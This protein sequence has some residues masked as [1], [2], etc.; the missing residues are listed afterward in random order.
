[1]QKNRSWKYPYTPLTKIYKLLALYLLIGHQLY[2]QSSVAVYSP[3]YLYDDGFEMIEKSNFNAARVSFENYLK[4]TVINGN[5]KRAFAEYYVAYSA[6]N[7]YNLDAEQLFVNFLEKYP[8]HP[9]AQKA[10]FDLGNFFFQDKNYKDAIRYLSKV[11]YTQLSNEQQREARFNLA[12]SYFNQRQFSNALSQFNML[13]RSASEYKSASAYYAAY[14]EF[15][16]KDYDDALTDLRIAESGDAYKSLVPVVICNIYYQQAK[17][18]ELIDYGEDILSN[19]TKLTNVKDIYLLTGEGYFYKENYAKANIFYQEFKKRNK[20]KPTTDVALRMAITDFNLNN[21]KEAIA[22]L[23]LIAGS[24]TKSGVA[25]SYYLGGLYTRENNMEFAA[26]AYKI[27]ANQELDAEISQKAL[28]QYGKISTDL[29]RSVEAINNLKKYLENYPSGDNVKEVND[30]LSLAY[31]NS[32]NLDLAIEHMETLS[33]MSDR[34][35]AAYQKA[36]FLKGNQLFNQHKYKPAIDHYDKSLKYPVDLNLRLE[37]HYW[38]SEAFA[39]GRLYEEAKPGYEIVI[40]GNDSDLKTK[41]SY[42]LGFCLFN[43]KEYAKA[44]PLYREFTN[45]YKGK[46]T[47]RIYQDATLRL[48][49]CYYVAKEYTRAQRMY[50]NAIQNGIREMDYAYLQLGTIENINNDFLSGKDHLRKLVNDFPHSSYVDDAL[51]ELASIDYERGNYQTCISVF[52][53]LIDEK[54]NSPYVPYSLQRRAISH[55]N[56]Q[57]YGRTEEDYRTFLKKY[58][59]H[60]EANNV[61]LGLQEVLAIQ[62]KSEEF[63]ELFAEFKAANPDS[64]GLEEVEFE[65]AKGYYNN[66]N[67]DRAITLLTAFMNAHPEDA[68]SYEAKFLIAE[69]YYRKGE[70]Y[71]A[72][73]LYYEI[74][75]ENQVSQTL[76]VIQR[77]ADLEYAARSFTK[78]INYYEKLERD[79]FTKRQTLNSWV[80]LMKSYFQISQYDEVIIYSANILDEGT[81]NVGTKNIALLYQGKVAYAVGNFDG[82]LELFEQTIVNAKDINA[83]EAQVLIGKVLYDQKKYKESNEVLFTISANFSVFDE[84]VGKGFLQIADNYMA[85]EENLQARATLNSIIE[86]TPSGIIANMAKAKLDRL[87]E[88]DALRVIEEDSLRVD[89]LFIE[90][91]DTTINNRGN[92]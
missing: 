3:E 34:S 41:A 66:Q 59:T 78:A 20:G 33:P 75:V 90:P 82:A 32:N 21:N 52:S 61:L 77:I 55:F 1:M 46:N 9:K 23:K 29:G 43:Q 4:R 36:T 16:Q 54:P 87:D 91:G 62:N 40:R 7:L 79:G 71:N 69:S 56:M 83:A 60:S 45:N 18:D 73:P 12:Y 44:L 88:L 64:E 68:K 35:K 15:S 65:T 84:W 58:P 72:L 80:G 49:D 10:S 27:A 28:F 11:D 85:M 5:P 24:N 6:L 19:R 81:V 22:N 53:Q 74:L 76:R 14:I 70:N 86:N 39:I 48:A 89:T 50:S 26:S 31:L 67:Y 63:D 8:S 51:F 25:A 42:G 17:Y 57:T 30:L 38:R 47:D 37:A 92:R 2:G 13:K